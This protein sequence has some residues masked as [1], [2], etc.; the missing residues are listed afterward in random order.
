MFG[1]AIGWAKGK[2]EKGKA[3]VKGKVEAGK[4]YVKGKVE[5]G[6]A[7]VKGKAKAGKEWVKEK[8]ADASAWLRQK[9]GLKVSTP[10]S[11]SKEKHTLSATIESETDV[12]LIMASTPELLI[13]KLQAAH[14]KADG[15]DKTKIQGLIAEANGV[16]VTITAL[17]TTEKQRLEARVKAGEARGVSEDFKRAKKL[18]A[19]LGM[20]EIMQLA[21]KLGVLPGIESIGTSRLPQI[22]K[23]LEKARESLKAHEQRIEKDR[24]DP[25][26]RIGL[27]DSKSLPTSSPT[28]T[29]EQKKQ[30]QSL[31]P[32]HHKGLPGCA[33]APP[34]TPDHQPPSELM[35]IIFKGKPLVDPQAQRL[36]PQ[37]R[38]HS[39][40]QGAA[41]KN[42][43]K[44]IK[45]HELV[46]QRID[47]L[48]DERKSWQNK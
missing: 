20:S 39:N 42:L 3:Y 1:G 44:R 19:Q 12:K 32:C 28:I 21:V 4:A 48:E 13:A 18:I 14:A 38:L 31:G 25:I 2:L 37:C 41:V 45:E 34:Y 5:A 16:M 46:Q 33:D 22:E 27:A 9:L 47:L 23:E 30:I 10:V 43:R 24:D 8:A 7:Y 6:K 17:V 26:F 36:Y 40:A 35:T 11:M 29:K 15:A